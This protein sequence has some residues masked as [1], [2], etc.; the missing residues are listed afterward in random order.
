MLMKQTLVLIS[1]LNSCGRGPVDDFVKK[2]INPQ[3][4]TSHHR[5]TVVEPSI[6]P[7]LD[8]FELLYKADV[9]IRIEFG[10][11]KS[12][13]AA[14]CNT[15]SDGYRDI[16]VNEEMWRKEGDLGREQ[17]IFHELGHC[18]LSRG[19][20]DT[21][22]TVGAYKNAAKSIMNSY[23]FGDSFVYKDNNSYYYTELFSVK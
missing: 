16:D 10:D 5:P 13:T 19:H 1:L 9:S 4:D 2:N 12:P 6:Q 21:L 17:V 22:T 3:D 11:L 20:N 7:Y 14:V 23:T 15:W 8:R 18:I